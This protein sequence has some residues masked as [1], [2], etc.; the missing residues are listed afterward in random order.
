MSMN[1]I[2]GGTH[3][4]G[5]E[6]VKALR[7]G[8]ED[9]YVVGRSYDAAR[10][11][12][13]EALDL[14]D[15]AAAKAFVGKLANMDMKSFYWVAGYGYM[16]DFGSQQDVERMVAVNFANAMPIAQAAWN[17]L[18]SSDATGNFVVISSSSGIKARNNEAVYAATKHAQVGLA[19]SLGLES[20]RLQTNLQV[21]LFLPG[22]MK[23]PF[24]EGNEP[25][26]LTEFL[27]PAKVAHHIV[28]V[29]STQQDLYYEQEIPRG[30]L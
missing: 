25:E 23:T 8:G 22:G 7:Q 24:W 19:C 6:I 13:G 3:G 16:G 4:L 30:S 15:A 12:T 1:L 28:G 11:G 18:L 20:E 21:A 5:L 27:D 9:V 2:L 14:S 26:N 10:D 17:K 29:V